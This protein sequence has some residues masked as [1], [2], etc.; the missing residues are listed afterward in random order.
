MFA[1]L[2]A[3]VGQTVF[4]AG[5]CRPVGEQAR[6]GRPETER[7]PMN[8]LAQAVLKVAANLPTEEEFFNGYKDVEVQLTSGISQVVRVSSITTVSHGKLL[9]KYQKTGDQRD[10]IRPLVA[11]QFKP[12]AFFDSLPPWELARLCNVAMAL[13]VGPKITRQIAANVAGE[14]DQ[15][16]IPGA[17]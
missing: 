9:K 6:P 2:F 7:Q 17:K 13:L 3:A 10:L 4:E 14:I 15:G 11:K 12:D 8:P 16:T 5:L 1:N